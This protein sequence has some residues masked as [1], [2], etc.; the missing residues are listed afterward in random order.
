MLGLTLAVAGIG[1]G[2]GKDLLEDGGSFAPPILQL[3]DPLSATVLHG[4][5]CRQRRGG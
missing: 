5:G 2:E 4:D 3:L 1:Q